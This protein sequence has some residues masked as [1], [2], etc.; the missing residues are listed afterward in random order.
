MWWSEFVKCWKNYKTFWTSNACLNFN[1]ILRFF[2]LLKPTKFACPA[3]NKEVKGV[4][5]QFATDLFKKNAE[6]FAFVRNQ[7]G[8]KEF[9]LEELKSVAEVSKEIDH[10]MK[11]PEWLEK[12]WDGGKTTLDLI[13]GRYNLGWG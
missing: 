13:K 5:E 1:F 3:F 7:T 6:F 2:Q 11:Q 10:G 9:G 8:F 12:K 4:Q